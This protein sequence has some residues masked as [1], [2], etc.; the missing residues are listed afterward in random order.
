MGLDL[1][2]AVFALLQT[3]FDAEQFLRYGWRLAFAVSIVL[4][5]VGVVVSLTVDGTPA[6]GLI[7]GA[8][9]APWTAAGYL[10]ATSVISVIATTWIRRVIRVP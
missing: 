8:G 9:G 3:V 7:H 5:V 6:F 1:G 10:V 2:T 4:V